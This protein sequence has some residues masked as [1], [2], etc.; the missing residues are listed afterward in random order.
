MTAFIFGRVGKSFAENIL[1]GENKQVTHLFTAA[2]LVSRKQDIK[3]KTLCK[4]LNMLKTC[5]SYCI[6]VVVYLD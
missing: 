6:L 1:V 3:N 5:T 4:Y 2:M